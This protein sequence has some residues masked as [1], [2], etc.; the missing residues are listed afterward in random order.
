MITKRYISFF[1]IAG[2][3]GAGCQKKPMLGAAG[4]PFSSLSPPP[5]G[6]SIYN[7]ELKKEL[8]VLE[9]LLEHKLDA[10]SLETVTQALMTGTGHKKYAD[11][12]EEA[13]LSRVFLA[14]PELVHP[15]E[16]L[17]PSR[18]IWFKA[19]LL[20]LRRRF[21]EAATGMSEVLKLE[22]NF[23]TARNWRARAIFFLGNPDLAINEL[24][25]I[26][27]NEPTHTEAHL[28]ALY[29]IGAIVY[30]SQD[31]DKKRLKGGIDAWHSYLRLSD[32]DPRMHQEITK[33]LSELS[34]RLK[35]DTKIQEILVD[36]FLP[37]DRYSE[38]KN[39]ILKS[40]NNE[41]LLLAE[42]L[43]EQYLSSNYDRDVAL[44][45]ARIYIKTGRI[46]EA[47]ELFEKITKENQ[48]YA[49]AFH[50]RGMAFMM[51]GHIKEAITSWEQALKLDTIY[52]KS[53]NLEQRIAVAKKMAEN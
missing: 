36:I 5:M 4:D 10:K 8:L 12:S 52:A 29:L 9:K 43:C 11:G 27:S 28:D 19:K 14:L 23:N 35:G 45:K 41:E 17:S 16:E 3:Y 22:P 20:F 1:V 31:L 25:K 26:I 24:N 51:K 48:N 40:F 34:D 49:P 7:D 6:A 21:V 53:H 32:P 46:D 15:K 33:S 38:N 18:K 44:I 39:K 50:Y 37:N 47:A 2:L 30:E 13:Y 42:K